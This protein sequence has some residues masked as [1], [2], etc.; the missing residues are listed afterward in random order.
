MVTMNKLSVIVPVYKDHENLT[1][2]ADKIPQL[3]NSI[4]LDWEVIFVIDP[5]SSNKTESTAIQLNSINTRFKFIVMARRFGQATAIQCG[6]QESVADVYIIMDVD[7]QDPVSLIPEM[8]ENWQQGFKIVLP[9]RLSRKGETYFRVI[10]TTVGYW[11]LNRYSKI[12]IPKSVGDFRLID[13]TIRDIL[14][15]ID[16][17]YY[18]LRGNIAQIG[19]PF[20]LIDFH[21]EERVNGESNYSKYLGSLSNAVN[22][23]FG[24]T[25]LASRVVLTTLTISILFVAIILGL[26]IGG[27]NNSNEIVLSLVSILLFLSIAISCLLFIYILRIH[28]YLFKRPRF[29]ILSKSDDLKLQES[30]HLEKRSKNIIF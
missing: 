25:N 30:N 5:D 26:N 20:K 22:A 1:A 11:L 18:F 15:E 12:N 13:K 16:D 21:R 4:K 6:L 8:I 17:P 3:M 2:F 7:G 9:R 19:F 24:Y 27:L 28:D 10:S 14:L 23:I 29:Q